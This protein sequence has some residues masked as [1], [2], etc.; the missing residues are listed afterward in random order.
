[1]LN[2]TLNDFYFIEL[3]NYT[4]IWML[5][6]SQGEKIG[7]KKMKIWI[8]QPTCISLD[9][10]CYW[11]NGQLYWT[12]KT[13]CKPKISIL[14]LRTFISGTIGCRQAWLLIVTPPSQ[15]LASGQ[16]NRVLPELAGETFCGRM[17]GKELSSTLLSPKSPL[18]SCF[19]RVP[20][21]RSY[22]HLTSSIRP[23]NNCLI[24]RYPCSCG[25]K[26]PGA[27]CH[28]AWFTRP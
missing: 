5:I 24:L 9:S 18:H 7:A 11:F 8:W 28:S 13:H 4:K 14:G 23:K 10:A 17:L 25:H 2:S 16:G 6:L 19:P 15:I 22:A 3:D 26:I 20:I 1:M 27:R 12:F 21:N